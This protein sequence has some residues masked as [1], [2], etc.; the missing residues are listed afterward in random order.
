MTEEKYLF[1][2]KICIII[3]WSIIIIFFLIPILR[4]NFRNSNNSNTKKNY[5]GVLIS[6]KKTDICYSNQ[7]IE[8][9]KEQLYKLNLND[10]D[11]SVNNCGKI[12]ISSGSGFHPKRFGYITLYFIGDFDKISNKLNDNINFNKIIDDDSIF[13]ITDNIDIDFF[14]TD[15]Y[16]ISH[17]IRMEFIVPN[18][19][20]YY[21]KDDMSDE[22]PI[23]QILLKFNEENL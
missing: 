1:L 8:L 3:F 14:K 10:E 17:E 5:H 2:K 12:S 6:H 21:D 18:L 22:D 19:P 20:H 4:K 15:N 23:V 16:D 7:E 11:F 13:I 9:F